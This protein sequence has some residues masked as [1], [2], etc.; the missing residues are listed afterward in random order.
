[1]L[2]YFERYKQGECQQVWDELTA[3]GANVRNASVYHDAFAV[4]RETMQRVR[5]NIHV[6]IPRLEAS[7]Y[8]FGYGWMAEGPEA[9]ADWIADQPARST[10]P[11]EDVVS[12]IEQLEEVAGP[13]PFSLRAFYSEVGEVNFV[14]VHPTWEERFRAYTSRGLEPMNLDPLVVWGL[15]M[16]TLE[17]ARSWQER[18]R[19]PEPY[20]L[21]IAA[22][23]SLKYNVS[24]AGGYEIAL[25][26]ASAD[27]PLLN[28]WHQTTFVNYLRTC[29]H[30][31]GL[32]GLERIR[33]VIPD[34]L[35][36]LR[37]GLLPI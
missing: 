5:Q 27:A 21:P 32:P 36:Y 31:G 33:H 24:G 14:G 23:A 20:L 1:M 18:R 25:P 13:L 11:P 4:A 9:D 37:Q 19:N 34:E 8:H 12:R 17:D 3:L 22:D 6:L 2:S 10:P 26:D 28:E 29:L 15:R 7:G 35:E 16:E 30:Y